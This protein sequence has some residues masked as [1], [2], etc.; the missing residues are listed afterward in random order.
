MHRIDGA[1]PDMDAVPE[2]GVGSPGQGSGL[3][4]LLS[5]HRPGASLGRPSPLARRSPSARGASLAGSPGGRQALFPGK[6][7]AGGPPRAGQAGG[8]QGPLEAPAPAAG[9]AAK[10]P[11]VIELELAAVGVGLRFVELAGPQARARKLCRVR[12]GCTGRRPHQ[13][14]PASPSGVRPCSELGNGNGV[15]CERSASVYNQSVHAVRCSIACGCSALQAHVLYTERDSAARAGYQ[16]AAPGQDGAPDAAKGLPH[17]ARL[18]AAYLDL[19]ADCRLS[20]GRVRA[21]TELRGLR[22]E[23]H[24]SVAGPD[25]EAVRHRALHIEKLRGDRG[26]AVLLRPPCHRPWAGNAGR[27]G[28]RRLR[29]CIGSRLT[30]GRPKEPPASRAKAGPAARRTARAGACRRRYWSHAGWRRA[31][32]W[33][34]ARATSRRGGLCGPARTPP[35]HLVHVQRH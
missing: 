18:L 4:Q 9:A 17:A 25:G 26:S 2:L 11:P 15:A 35:G 6:R 34:T 5:P 12:L 20:G 22:V 16:G 19:L 1:D 8:A 14:S 7:R 31:P 24:L 3:G 28:I 29:T 21:S 13:G 33:P 30:W 10:P 27:L 23:T 32:T